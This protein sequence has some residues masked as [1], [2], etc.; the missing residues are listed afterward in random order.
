MQN[1]STSFE[2]NG[3]LWWIAHERKGKSLALGSSFVLVGLGGGL[4]PVVDQR[5]PH[6]QMSSVAEGMRLETRQRQNM[7]YSAE[8]QSGTLERTRLDTDEN[9]AQSQ[10][11]IWSHPAASIW[12]TLASMWQT[13]ASL[14][15][16]MLVKPLSSL[17][18]MVQVAQPAF[19]V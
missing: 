18:W 7:F 1:G 5:H 19:V 12:D 17:T 9:H 2:K 14:W 16:N 13:M 11:S 4:L 3:C 10:S 8:L 6:S 15:P